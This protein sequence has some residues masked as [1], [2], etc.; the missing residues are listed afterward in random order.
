MN[1]AGG[2]ILAY[3]NYFAIFWNVRPTSLDPS[4]Q[5]PRLNFSPFPCEGESITIAEL[6][7]T[8][9]I[10]EYG[11][12]FRGSRPFM[13]QTQLCHPGVQDAE[14]SMQSNRLPE[15]CRR[16]VERFASAGVR[17]SDN[18]RAAA[19]CRSQAPICLL[20]VHELCA[21]PRIRSPK[22]SLRVFGGNNVRPM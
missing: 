1:S 15:V 18:D 22:F 21:Q 12:S 7:L 11:L 17:D 13:Y 3:L 5:P 19:L 16:C 14:H 9:Q 2:R 6:C 20:G 8:M 10:H 4:A